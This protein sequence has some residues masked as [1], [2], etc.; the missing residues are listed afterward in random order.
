[1]YHFDKTPGLKVRANDAVR[2]NLPASFI[3][4]GFS[5]IISVLISRANMTA[6]FDFIHIGLGKCMSS[7]LQML[8]ANCANY[9]FV[10]GTDVSTA[11]EN[12]VRT[13]NPNFEPILSGQEQIKLTFPPAKKDKT[14]VMST[15]GFT[16]SFLHEAELADA[17]PAKGKILAKTLAGT[18]PKVLILIRNPVDWIRSAHAQ[19]LKEGGIIGLNEYL[20]SH[21][22]TLL[23][24]L[25]LKTIIDTWQQIG[26]EVIV[27]PIELAKQNDE[28]FWQAY[29]KRLGAKRPTHWQ[30]ELDP[31]ANN[32]TKYE[33]VSAHQQINELLFKLQKVL[34]PHE[35]QEK[36]TA[37]KALD[38]ARRLST[39]R[40]MAYATN[41]EMAEIIASLNLKQ[42]GDKIKTDEEFR[43]ALKEN[44]ITP[45][46]DDPAFA[47]Y[48]CLE[49]YSNSLEG[50]V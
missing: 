8:W 7:R 24:N 6:N 25:D 43:D 35:F 32:Q 23:N 28:T 4:A 12:V 41:D 31:V 40:V 50:I 18:A 19:Q 33:T 44:F 37:I 36:E 27:L 39:R 10:S 3:Q 42:T 5:I 26:A 49:E 13:Y 21:R 15:E 2:L 16:F 45:L 29:E 9:N 11:I 1:L 20:K 34:E 30:A 14:N 47:A 22:K 38:I 46:A 48:N 17:I